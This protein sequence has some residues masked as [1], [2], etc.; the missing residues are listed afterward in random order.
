[1]KFKI[2]FEEFNNN[3]NLLLPHSSINFSDIPW[4]KHPSCE[5]VALKHLITSIHT[6][7]EF[8]YHLVKIDPNKKINIHTHKEQLE[9]HEVI[10]GN[11]ICIY[12]NVQIGY[13]PGVITILP[14]NTPHEVVAGVNGLYLF[15]KFIPALI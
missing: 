7:S 12:D 1:M 14:K 11:G 15:A 9:T 2:L 5:G 3:G 10:S 4:S 6:N 8:S 13:K